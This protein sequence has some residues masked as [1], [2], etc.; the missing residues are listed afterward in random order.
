MCFLEG[1]R[2]QSR[3]IGSSYRSLMVGTRPAKEGWTS[4]A[5]KTKAK[6]E[7]GAIP[8]IVPPFPNRVKGP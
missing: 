2:V 1:S 8:Q 7:R 5:V 3:S 4:A 6:S